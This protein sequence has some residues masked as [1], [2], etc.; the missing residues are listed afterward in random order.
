MDPTPPARARRAI[1]VSLFLCAL[2]SPAGAHERRKVGPFEVEVGWATEP[3]FA[4]AENG[5]QLELTRGERPVEEAR[6]V[7]EIVFGTEA[8]GPRTDTLDLRPVLGEPG[9]YRAFII[10]TR[11]GSYLLDV[12]GRAG[13]VRIRETFVSG[14]GTFD[15]V[16]NP[17]DVEFPVED[18]TRGEL[19]E[20]LERLD[21]R[22]RELAAD[23]PSSADTLARILGAAGIVIGLLGLIAAGRA[24]RSQPGG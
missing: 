17:A 1:A 15:D 7:V 14:T 24:R 2:A 10:P 8:S 19:A 22:V 3:A 16:R 18:P 13:G 21:E 11:P 23:E 6:L 5:V 4:G 20:R 9:E 12:R